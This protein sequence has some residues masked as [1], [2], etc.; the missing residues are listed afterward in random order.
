MLTTHASGTVHE[1][2]SPTTFGPMLA[3]VTT[4]VLGTAHCA[5]TDAAGMFTLDDVP[6]GDIGLTFSK[7]GYLR[8]A[9]LMKARVQDIT[10]FT[11]GVVTDAIEQTKLADAGGTYPLA[12]TGIVEIG[13]FVMNGSSYDRAQGVTE[14]LA[15]HTAVYLGVDGFPDQ[16][17]TSSSAEGGVMFVNVAPADVEVTVSLAGKNCAS[18]GWN[19]STANT[20]R[21]PA[22][23]DTLTYIPVLCL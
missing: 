4:C 1:W 11:V 12:G 21:I 15:G 6:I 17:L 9:I 7:P 20:L 14:S 22:Q 18:D 23:A 16:A 2:M 8:T 3:D 10:G 13:A 5:Q 19:G